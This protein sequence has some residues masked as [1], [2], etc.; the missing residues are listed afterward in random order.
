MKTHL[1]ME[2]VVFSAWVDTDSQGIEKLHTNRYVEVCTLPKCPLTPETTSSE[3]FQP[4]DETSF[5]KKNRKA[6]NAI[7]AS[8]EE[9]NEEKLR[10]YPHVDNTLAEHVSV[11]ETENA[12]GPTLG[13]VRT[14]K[15]SVS[16][17]LAR[18]DEG[19]PILPPWKDVT[20]NGWKT[21]DQQ[22]LLRSFFSIYYRSFHPFFHIND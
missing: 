1:G 9:M 5:L 16:L 21:K 15:K 2:V 20:G 17:Q 12:A 14:G 10:K 22:Q 6:I 18:N 11:G 3:T 8:W 19:Y 7:F 4:T 13:P